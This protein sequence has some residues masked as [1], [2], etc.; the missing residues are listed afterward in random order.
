MR[1]VIRMVVL[2]GATAAMSWLVVRWL[3]IRRTAATT[4]QR[5]VDQWEN[6]G[7]ALA[8]PPEKVETSV[9]H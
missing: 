8:P 3:A 4:T 6:E 9:S 2:A 5:P 1:E 7:G